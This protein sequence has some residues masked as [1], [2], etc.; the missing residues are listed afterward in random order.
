MLKKRT[1]IRVKTINIG[2][3]DRMLR[4]NLGFAIFLLSI[5]VLHVGSAVPIWLDESAT[6][7]TWAYIAILGAIYPIITAIYGYDPF[8]AILKKDTL[9]SFLP[10]MAY[11]HIATKHDSKNNKDNSLTHSF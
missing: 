8:Y 1:K 6:L 9:E 3:I 10:E 4:F 11:T 7:P 5:V 2:I